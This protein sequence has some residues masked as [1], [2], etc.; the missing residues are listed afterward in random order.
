MSEQVSPE[1]VFFYKEAA[2]NRF[3]F[4]EQKSITATQFYFPYWAE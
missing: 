4:V 3:I 2:T 1:S